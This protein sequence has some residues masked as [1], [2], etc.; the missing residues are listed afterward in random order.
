[1]NMNIARVKAHATDLMLGKIGL[2]T[3]P[4]TTKKNS[5]NAIGC[6]GFIAIT[7]DGIEVIHRLSQLSK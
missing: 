5:L 2:Q 6:D 3:T 7:L 1:M 4:P